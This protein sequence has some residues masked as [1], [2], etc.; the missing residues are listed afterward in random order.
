MASAR[1]TSGNRVTL[2]PDSGRTFDEMLRLI[3]GARRSVDLESY[4]FKS[5]A[6][7]RRFLGALEAAARRGV[8]V[9]LLLDWVGRLGTPMSFFDPL[10][11]SGAVVRV[12]NRPGWRPWFGLLPRD[13]R[14][15]LVVDGHS[16]V[17]GGIGIGDEWRYGLLRRHRQPWRDTCVRIDGPA[18]K[19]LV[20]AFRKTWAIAGGE[21]RPRRATRK[22]APG[23]TGGDLDPATAQPS[24]VG[25][26]EGEPGRLRMGRALHLQAAAAQR[27]IWI[28]SAYFVPSFAEVEALAGAARDGVD[29]RLLVPSKYDHIWNHRLTTRYYDRL[30]RNKVRIWEWRGEMMH[31]KT[32]VIDGRWTRV[33]STDFNPL[34]VAINYELDAM[35]EDPAI[36]AAAEAMF[37]ADLTRSREV[38]RRRRR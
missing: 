1:V 10:L 35:I 38:H 16:G 19:D 33:G 2:L 32:T 29:V 37:L 18:A 31:A 8:R 9:R 11:T 28:A 30:L 7:G 36:G 34:G 6:T 4:I 22:L 15:L 17:T 21:K 3:D 27:S 20:A 23:T 12:F 24:L 5:D 14:K 25:I 26:I 13:H